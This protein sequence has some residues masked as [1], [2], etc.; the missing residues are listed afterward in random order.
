M[1]HDGDLEQDESG[2]LRVS[3]RKHSVENEIGNAENFQWHQVAQHA[4]RPVEER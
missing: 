4:D 2:N 1:M 3:K